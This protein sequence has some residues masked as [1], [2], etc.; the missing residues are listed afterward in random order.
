MDQEYV[1]LLGQ[2]GEGPATASVMDGTFV[3]PEGTSQATRDFIE[4]CREIEEMEIPPYEDSFKD[5]LPILYEDIA[6]AKRRHAHM[7]NT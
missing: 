1:R 7:R 3:F 4:A 6:Y 5:H 2:Y